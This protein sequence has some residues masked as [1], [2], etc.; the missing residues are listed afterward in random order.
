MFSM[1]LILF[2]MSFLARLYGLNPASS[3]ADTLSLGVSAVVIL[4]GA[5]AMRRP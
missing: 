5:L 3:I 4:V 2:F 1:G